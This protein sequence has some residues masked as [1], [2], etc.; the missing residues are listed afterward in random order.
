[1]IIYE[2]S[3]REQQQKRKKWLSKKKPAQILYEN[4]FFHESLFFFDSLENSRD[5][6]MGH[7]TD[8]QHT[9]KKYVEMSLLFYD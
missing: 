3:E 8:E 1:M 6:K 7:W 2:Q 9:K 4:G 5:K